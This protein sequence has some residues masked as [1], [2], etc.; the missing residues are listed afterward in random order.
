ME[1]VLERLKDFCIYNRYRWHVILGTFYAD[2]VSWCKGDTKL[3]STITNW[4]TRLCSCWTIWQVF[5]VPHV[6]WPCRNPS[7]YLSGERYRMLSQIYNA[8]LFSPTPGIVRCYVLPA[9]H[10]LT[11]RLIFQTVGRRPSE[12]YQRSYWS[13]AKLA[14]LTPFRSSSPKF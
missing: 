13:Y 10:F 4:R 14:K 5:A 3:T 1:I 12:L 9:V 8:L 7:S 6:V 2:W 11:H